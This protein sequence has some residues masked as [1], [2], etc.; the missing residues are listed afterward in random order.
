MVLFEGKGPRANCVL[1]REYLE[2]LN[3]VN[4]F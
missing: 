1:L 4:L 2:F 3:S